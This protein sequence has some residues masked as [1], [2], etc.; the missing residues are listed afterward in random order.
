MAIVHS[1]SGLTG[2]VIFFSFINC[3]DVFLAVQ[4]A[5]TRISGRPVGRLNRMF[6][7]GIVD[8]ALAR[9]SA[10]FFLGSYGDMVPSAETSFIPSEKSIVFAAL[11]DSHLGE[12]T[13]GFYPWGFFAWYL[14]GRQSGRLDHQSRTGN[15]EHFLQNAKSLLLIMIVCILVSMINPQGYRILTFSF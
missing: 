15:A 3:H 14:C 7:S 2:T 1:A 5:T 4:D 6:R 12:L 11:I 13:A 9:T 10:H 8:A